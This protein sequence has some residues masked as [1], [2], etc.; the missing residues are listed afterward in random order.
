MKAID[1]ELIEESRQNE[2]NRFLSELPD[3][4]LPKEISPQ[5]TRHNKF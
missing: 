5:K 4:T 2:N 1:L 3:L